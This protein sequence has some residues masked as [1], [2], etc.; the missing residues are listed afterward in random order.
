VYLC[1]NIYLNP[2]VL[3]RESL[4]SAHWV[5]TRR[6]PPCWGVIA[7]WSDNYKGTAALSEL[8][9]LKQN[10]NHHEDPSTPYSRRSYCCRM[11]SIICISG[12]ARDAITVLT[13]LGPSRNPNC[14][15]RSWRCYEYRRYGANPSTRIPTAAAKAGIWFTLLERSI[16]LQRQWLRHLHKRLL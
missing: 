2:C 14:T 5:A 8:S 16:N 1:K 9:E 15:L 13:P 11:D 7:S 4:S 12:A 10:C 3:T 6:F